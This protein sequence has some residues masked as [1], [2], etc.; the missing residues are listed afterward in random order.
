MCADAQPCALTHRQANRRAVAWEVGSEVFES[1]G[2]GRGGH[3]LQADRGCAR[4][5]AGG[6]VPAYR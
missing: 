6:Y 3:V 4:Q 5:Q 2:L 1:V